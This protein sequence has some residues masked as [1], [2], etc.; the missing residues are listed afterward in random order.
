[1]CWSYMHTYIFHSTSETVRQKNMLSSVVTW[2]SGHLEKLQPLSHSKKP[3]Y[4]YT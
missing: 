4:M 2:R 3:K 1:M